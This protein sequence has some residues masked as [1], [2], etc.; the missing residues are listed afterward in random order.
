MLKGS[1]AIDLR[2]PDQQ[3]DSY[4]WTDTVNLADH[5]DLNEYDSYAASR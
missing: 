4:A 3:T 2:V 1:G 5:F